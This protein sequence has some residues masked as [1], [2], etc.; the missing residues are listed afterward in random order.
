M[1][2]RATLAYAMLPMLLVAIGC[3]S[4]E[5][6][7]DLPKVEE[8]APAPVVDTRPKS[9]PIG[10]PTRQT[11]SAIGGVYRRA[12]AETEKWPI[13]QGIQHFQAS[14]G[15]LP[16]SNEEF[17]DKVMKA[18]QIPYPKMEEGYEL[19]FDPDTYDNETFGLQQQLVEEDEQDEAAEEPAPENQPDPFVP[20][21]P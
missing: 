21:S 10:E 9:V 6:L 18:M 14:N 3:G 19:V 8:P 1:G 20:P 2:T 4:S 16:K 13:A 15:R 12:L 7:P 11:Q 17:H 5:P